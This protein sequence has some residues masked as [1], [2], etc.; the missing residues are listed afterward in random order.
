MLLFLSMPPLLLL[1]LLRLLL[2]LL[3]LS[4]DFPWQVEPHA[5]RHGLQQ[6]K[7]A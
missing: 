4:H 3:Q 7:L 1:L 6:L 5:G 2:L